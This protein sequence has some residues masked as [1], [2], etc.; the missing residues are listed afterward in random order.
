MTSFSS[1]SW[2]RIVLIADQTGATV[3]DNVRRIAGNE[4]GLQGL[5][6]LGGGCHL[7]RHTGLLQPHLLGGELGVVDAISAVED[8]GVNR[9]ARLHS[10]G[11]GVAH[12]IRRGGAGG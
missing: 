12:L 1:A 6:D 11:I 5:G 4:A 8:D 9:R 10:E 7:H 3:V 2:S